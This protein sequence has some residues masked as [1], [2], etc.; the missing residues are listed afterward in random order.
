MGL[1]FNETITE[2]K[3]VDTKSNWREIENFILDYAA[4]SKF[5]I[6]TN[7]GL[8]LVSQD[9][10]YSELIACKMIERLE[11]LSSDFADD[12]TSVS[13]TLSNKSFI[14]SKKFNFVF[15]LE[16]NDG[17]EEMVKRRLQN[18]LSTYEKFFV[19]YKDYI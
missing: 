2:E 19:S 5:I 9:Q 11:A 7:E 4:I 10:N 1:F 15:I 6:T 18:V 12:V 13:I 3:K 17:A 16:I 8:P 14:I